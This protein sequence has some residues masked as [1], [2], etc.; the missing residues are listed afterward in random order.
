MLSV[1]HVSH[2]IHT[3]CSDKEKTKTEE[4]SSFGL[5]HCETCADM[6][7][8]EKR[9][10]RCI[11]LVIFSSN[12][13]HNHLH[14][15]RC[16]RVCAPLRA[17]LNKSWKLTRSPLWCMNINVTSDG[18]EWDGGKYQFMMRPALGQNISLW[19]YIMPPPSLQS[20]DELTIPKCFNQ[21]TI[22]QLRRRWS[23]QVVT[24]RTLKR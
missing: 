2:W 11:A 24:P 10:P 6:R 22:I 8:N 5:N 13:T 23:V 20:D 19:A 12:R 1:S 7:L 14:S 17:D 15:K 21:Y 18:V 4:N 16:W 3:F 9:S